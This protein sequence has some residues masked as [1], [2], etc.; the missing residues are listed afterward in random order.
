MGGGASGGQIG[1]K[2]WIF[3]TELGPIPVQDVINV[4]PFSTMQV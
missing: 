4:M 3:Q 2:S 1:A